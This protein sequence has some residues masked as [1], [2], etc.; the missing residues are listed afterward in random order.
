L[1]NEENVNWI[2]ETLGA[3]FFKID[4]KEEWNITGSLVDHHPMY[5]FIPGKTRGEGLF[6]AVLRKH[7]ERNENETIHSRPA[8]LKVMTDE[9]PVSN[10]K[11]KDIPPHSKA[12]SIHFHQEEYP[13]VDI[14]YQQAI[15]YL[16]KEAIILPAETPKGFVLLTYQHI[17]IGFA[18]NIGNRANNLYPMEWRIKSTHI[19]EHETI[20]EFA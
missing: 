16:R 6:V 1:E 11:K 7:V 2:A 5:R 14:N 8:C 10:G 12:L 17:P 9:P 20:L 13:N 19:P 4:T 3:D 15:S 18:K